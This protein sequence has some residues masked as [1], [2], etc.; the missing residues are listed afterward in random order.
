MLRLSDLKCGYLGLPAPV[1]TAP[2]IEIAAGRFVCVIGRNGAGKST[3]MRTISGLQKPLA[4]SAFL[5]G[6]EIAR[7]GARERAQ[8]ITVVTTERVS[9]PGLFARDVVELGRQPFTNWHG[10]LGPDDLGAV[11]Q[12][13]AQTRSGEFSAKLFDALSDGERQ[14]VMIARALAQSPRMMVLDEITAFLDLPGRV[15]IMSLLRQ[16]AHETGTVVLISSHDL[17][18]SLELADELWVVHAG[19]LHFG[20][21]KDSSMMH[22]I[23]DSFSSSGVQFDTISGRFTLSNA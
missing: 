22:L 23:A 19:A 9:S 6:R 12:A 4:G 16:H 20:G 18:L 21:P 10:R 3:L 13:V 1:V 7:L 14:R 17:E 5:E 2:N 8:D 11:A 15:E